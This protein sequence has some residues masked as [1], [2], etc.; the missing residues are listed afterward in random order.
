MPASELAA[1]LP[2]PWRASSAPSGCV[3]RFVCVCSVREARERGGG[4]EERGGAVE[5]KRSSYFFKL[6]I[7]SA[8]YS[9]QTEMYFLFRLV[10][11]SIHPCHMHALSYGEEA[12][13]S[14]YVSS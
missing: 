5:K 8:P 11:G 9:L 12:R 6:I 7:P 4:V 2:I 1:A 13:L 3:F 10:A 14:R